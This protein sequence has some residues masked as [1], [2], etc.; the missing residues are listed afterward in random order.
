MQIFLNYMMKWFKFF[1]IIFLF[2]YTAIVFRPFIFDSKLPIPADT[3]VGLYHPWR[4][5]YSKD[6]SSGIPFKNF[7]ITDP[8]RQQFPWRQLVVENI[9]KGAVPSWNPYNFSGI[10]LLANLQ[11]AT[12]YPL[13]LVFFLT[14]FTAGWS[15][16]II[17]QVILGGIFMFLYLRNLGLHSFATTLGTLAFVGSGF[18][19]SWLEWNTLIQSALWLPLILL[20][21]EK[22]NPPVFIFSLVSSFFAGHLQVFFY[23]C[24]TTLLYILFKRKSFFVFLTSSLLTLVFVLPQ[25]IPTLAFIKESARSLDQTIWNRPEWFLPWQN[26]VQLVAPDF[27][28]HPA[29]L[30]YTGIFSYQEFV[31]YIGIIPFI[32]AV[33]GFF[34]AKENLVWFFRILLVGSLVMALPTFLAKL[35]FVLNVPLISSASPARLIFLVDFSMAILAAFGLNEFLKNRSPKKIVVIVFALLGFLSCLLIS[36]KANNLAVSMRN[37]YLPIGL[38]L[39]FGLLLLSKST[40][41]IIAGIL[42]ITL[43]DLSRFAIKFESFSDPSYLYP[44]TKAL[45]FL[46][47]K[48]KTDLFR[49]AAVDDRI[50]PPN[51]SIMYKIQSISGYDP[52]YLRRYGLLITAIEQGGGFNRI[53]VPKNYSSKF[54]DLLNVK[55]ILTLA[56]I[57]LDKYKLV[58]QEGETRVYQNSSVLPRA[59]FVG[60]VIGVSSPEDGL[61]KMFAKNF[62]VSDNAAVENFPEAEFLISKNSKVSVKDYQDNRVV[63]ETENQNDGFLVLTDSYYPGWQAKV[64]GVSTPIFPSNVAFRGI[65][66]PSGKHLVVFEYPAR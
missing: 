31:S 66:I 49:V 9:Q 4:D 51:F 59:F 43:F 40:K 55:Y 6:Y 65:F 42:L 29:T 39:G 35:P 30:N 26:L 60:K 5:F 38:T 44:A 54:F 24:L 22:I 10:P 62:S 1:P 21:V 53:I 16:Q 32:F 56:D 48:S 25:L 47:E 52:L 64:D 13:N 34:T 33:L 18:F 46:Q 45:S 58:F 57:K 41:I 28:G 15:I 20:A 3:I 12:F 19:V 8:V 63:L 37:L 61:Q 2:L 17:F 11:S 7:L 23:V 50:L 27:F 36:A 14:N